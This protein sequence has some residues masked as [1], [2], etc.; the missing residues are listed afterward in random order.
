MH[1]SATAA[2]RQRKVHKLADDLER[3]LRALEDA[4]ERGDERD[5]LARFEAVI[6]ELGAG[7]VW[8]AML[9][10]M[11]WR[12]SAAR[13]AALAIYARDQHHGV[14]WMAKLDLA[15]TALIE[16]V[17]AWS[18]PWRGRIGSGPGSGKP[19]DE[20]GEITEI[21]PVEQ[22]IEDLL[23]WLRQEA[24][25]RAIAALDTYIPL[26]VTRA[27]RESDWPK[28]RRPTVEDDEIGAV[29]QNEALAAVYEATTTVRQREV[30]EAME[31]HAEDADDGNEIRCRAAADLDMSRANLRNIIKRI[32]D[33]REKK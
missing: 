6:D 30:L 21:I 18:E 11:P 19:R 8:A 16:V 25:A 4:H 31:R 13:R 1:R 32:I 24:L 29:R 3:A 22:P 9:A 28:D 5:V 7:L 20:A 27:V 33:G 23:V 17:G 14:A 15:L 12:L 10:D 2:A 26:A